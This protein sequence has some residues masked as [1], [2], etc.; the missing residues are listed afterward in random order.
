M[1][2]KLNKVIQ[3]NGALVDLINKDKENKLLFSSALRLRLRDNFVGIKEIVASYQEENNSLVEKYGTPITGQPQYK[4]VKQDS[5][6]WEAFKTEFEAM[7][8][9]EYDVTIK[10]LT[11]SELINAETKEYRVDVATLISLNDLGLVVAD[12][13]V[14]QPPVKE[15][16]KK[17]K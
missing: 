12:A 10:P 2:I 3:I 17:P 15:S 9:E 1:A 13:Q 8:N 5:E 7:L 11:E 4:E 14:I 6:N 16:K